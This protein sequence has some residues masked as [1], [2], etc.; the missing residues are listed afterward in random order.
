MSDQHPPFAVMFAEEPDGAILILTRGASLE[1]AEG[2]LRVSRRPD[3]GV[4]VHRLRF[5]ESG[6]PSWAALVEE[7]GS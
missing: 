2:N 7:E 4:D 1:G 3:G 6:V 5:N